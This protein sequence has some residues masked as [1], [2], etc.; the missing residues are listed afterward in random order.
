MLWGSVAGETV[1]CVVC[2][3]GI[4][5]PLVYSNTISQPVFLNSSV[6]IV[7]RQDNPMLGAAHSH[8]GPALSS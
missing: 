6:V 5:W 3:F 2:S 7:E 8:F 4:V 1:L